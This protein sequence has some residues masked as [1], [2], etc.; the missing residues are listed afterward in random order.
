MSNVVVLYGVFEKT[1][2]EYEFDF[3]VYMHE[4]I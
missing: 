1:R 4:T 3:S 2:I